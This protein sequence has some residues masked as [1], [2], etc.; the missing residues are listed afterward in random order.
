MNSPCIVTTRPT[1]LP[2]YLDIATRRRIAGWAQAER[3]GEPAALQVLDSGR[4]L[5]RVIANQHRPD[6]MK[7]GFGDGRFGFD[8]LIPA[9]LSGHE[10][11]VIQ[12]R[13]E[14][15]GT[16]LTG[17]PIVL[18][19]TGAF[20]DDLRALLRQAAGGAQTNEEREDILAFLARVA[21]ELLTD[22]ARADGGQEQREHYR[23]LARRY[24]PDIKLETAVSRALVIDEHLP[25]AGRDAGSQALLSHARSLQ[26]LGYEVSLIAA[27]DLSPSAALRE[28]LEEDG[29]RIWH[30][31]HY[32]SVE[33][34]LRRQTGAF[35][36]VYLHRIG[37]A[38]RYLNLVRHHQPVAAVLYSVADLHHRRLAGQADIERRPELHAVSRR[39]RL[40]ECTA[41]WQA[42]VVLTHSPVE[43]A[44]LRQVVPDARVACVPWDMRIREQKPDFAVRRGIAFIGNYTHAPNLDAVIWFVDHVLPGLRDRVAGIELWLVGPDLPSHLA[45]PDSVR[46]V[47]HVEDLDKAVFDHIRLTVAP[48][49]FGAGIKGKVLESLL[50]GIPCVMTSVAAEGL[51]FPPSLA[52]LVEDDVA[53]QIARIS[54]LYADPDECRA[55]GEQAQ[56]YIATMFNADNTITSLRKAIVTARQPR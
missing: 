17:S 10:R 45:W 30:S 26:A 39:I 14:S 20:D 29:F 16:E 34:I 19:A 56:A 46:I 1:V 32:A 21:D 42:D 11:H 27:N 38:S 52:T 2:G 48:L 33:E 8:L 43:A 12:V 53:G 7:A 24:G 40:Q 28:A 13:R 41:A 22:H 9:P 15:D 3:D 49:R 35:E 44:W 4:L 31:P 6:L 55:L 5:A 37:T 23:R 51:N 18:E 54:A 36:L 50:A 25:V 47:G